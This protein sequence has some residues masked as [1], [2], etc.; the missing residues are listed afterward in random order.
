MAASATQTSCS[1]PEVGI[2]LPWTARLFFRLSFL[3]FESDCAFLLVLWDTEF[4]T[5]FSSWIL[6]LFHHS[7]L[8]LPLPH[9]PAFEIFWALT[10]ITSVVPE[11]FPFC[12][13]PCSSGFCPWCPVFLCSLF[14]WSRCSW[15][16]KVSAAAWVVQILSCFWSNTVCWIICLPA[17]INKVYLVAC[18]RKPNLKDFKR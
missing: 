7:S 16:L 15:I 18:N 2:P 13:F 10:S 4:L 12:F 6:G 9:T 5:Q 17:Y 11:A 8:L 1:S 14:L 3:N